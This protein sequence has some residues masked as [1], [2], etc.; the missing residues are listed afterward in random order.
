MMMSQMK[1]LT[2]EECLEMSALHFGGSVFAIDQPSH[3]ND[4]P[5]IDPKLKFA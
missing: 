5:P 1:G 4:A 2:A 3:G